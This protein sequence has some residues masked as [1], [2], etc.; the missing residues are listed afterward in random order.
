M[1]P[2]TAI[3]ILD[4]VARYY[5]L[6]RTM[7]QDLCVP[8]DSRDGRKTRKLLH[9]LVSDGLLTRN[10]MEVVN[11]AMGAPAPVYSPSR[12]GCE[13]LACEWKDDR[14][15]HVCCLKPTWQN[16]YHWVQVAAFH[17]A[18]DRAVTLTPEVRVDGWL[19]EWDIANPDEKEP[20]KRYRLFT[21]LREKPR[22]VANPDAGFLL[23]VGK[24]AKAYY[25]EIDRS[26]TGLQQLAHSKPAGLAEMAAQQLHKRHFPTTTLDTFSV[27]FITLTANRRDALCRLFADKPGADLWKFACKDDLIGAWLHAPIFH[28]CHGEPAPLVRPSTSVAPITNA[29]SVVLTSD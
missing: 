26:T 19:S 2:T 21:L 6:T 20:H 15:L 18:L 23:R 17:L 22:L 24:H 7:I 25:V 9:Q 13:Y 29:P 5:T 11:P 1:H 10:A 3:A 12:K 8:G 27:L 28:R 16:L 14:Y 4:A